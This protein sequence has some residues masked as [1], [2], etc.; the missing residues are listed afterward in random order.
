MEKRYDLICE[1]ITDREIAAI[2]I[3]PFNRDPNAPRV[4]FLH[5]LHGRKE[6]NLYDLY[7]LAGLGFR[8]SAIDLARHAERPG[9]DSLADYLEA[10]YLGAIQSIIFDTVQDVA[11]L[12]DYWKTADL[13]VGIIGV[14]AGGL[15]AHALAV[16]EPRITAVSAVITSPDWLNASV[17]LRPKAGSSMEMLISSLSPVNQAQAYAPKALLMLG[18]EEDDVLLPEGSRLLF[19]RLLPIY[20][21]LSICERLAL[22]IYPRIGHLYTSDMRELSLA[23]MKKFLEPTL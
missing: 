7:L 10:N 9:S 2:T 4:I 20:T 21:S 6:H 17:D 13:N 8:A 16:S 1:T 22:K 5:G 11:L 3:Q 14:S 18:G 12:L 15:I 23:W 19:D